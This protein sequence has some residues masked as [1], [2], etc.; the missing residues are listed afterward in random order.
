MTD[1]WGGEQ[2][3]RKVA[4]LE[5]RSRRFA[6]VGQDHQRSCEAS[7]Q[8]PEATMANRADEDG[9]RAARRS[10]GSA[11]VSNGAA[12]PKATKS[13]LK[14]RMTGG[15]WRAKG[16]A[17][18]RAAGQCGQRPA[19]TMSHLELP[20]TGGLR[21]TEGGRPIFKSPDG[22]EVGRRR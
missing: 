11:V 6:P 19:G 1:Q 9:Q 10:S 4:C 14:V 3:R 2:A 7:K 12:R 21:T 8:Q 15:Q 13:H 5:R 20:T 17:R 16:I 18:G 22:Y